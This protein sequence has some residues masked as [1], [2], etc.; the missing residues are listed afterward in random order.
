L[1]QRY[2]GSS[3]GFKN[4]TLL[5]PPKSHFT[6]LEKA[7]FGMVYF[8]AE[9]TK[10]NTNKEANYWRPLMQIMNNDPKVCFDLETKSVKHHVIKVDMGHD[11]TR[12][13]F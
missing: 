11:P 9:S 4:T 2:Q 10:K 5:Y 13:Y 1:G 3:I 12:A 7:L 8:D 6:W